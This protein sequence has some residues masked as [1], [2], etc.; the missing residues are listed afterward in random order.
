MMYQPC[1]VR[2][3]NKSLWM[4]WTEYV[5]SFNF[6]FKNKNRASTRK[7]EKALARNKGAIDA[8]A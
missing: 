6:G 3:A 8:V 7:V 1:S 2:L 4:I 5:N